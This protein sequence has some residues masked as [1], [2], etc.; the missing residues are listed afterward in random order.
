MALFHSQTQL[1][2]KIS[3]FALLT[4]TCPYGGNPFTL[5]GFVI[6]EA[7]ECDGGQFESVDVCP[8]KNM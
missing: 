4:V 2:M 1:N 7:R 5:C 6:S 8:G 3:I